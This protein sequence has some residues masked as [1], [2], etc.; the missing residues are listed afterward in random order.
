[1]M[2]LQT[3]FISV[4]AYLLGSIPTGKIVGNHYGVDIQKAGSGNIGFANA[5]RVLG[6]KPALIVLAGDAFKGFLAVY[7]SRQILPGQTPIFLAGALA[8]LGNVFPVWL[9]F[10][11]GKGIATGLGVTLAI[12]PLLALAGLMVYLSTIV[13]ARRSSV[14]SITSSW[15]LPL[16]CIRIAPEFVWYYLGLAV[17]ASW[18]H[19][20]NIMRI[21]AKSIIYDD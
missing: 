14:A 4:L 10:K 21:R 7:I 6:W 20:T 19:R 1:M 2:F 9:K 16:L 5:V 3:L 8:I 17:F 18:T 13:L 12:S 11:G 15:A